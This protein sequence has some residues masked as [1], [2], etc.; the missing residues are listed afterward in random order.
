M[1]MVPLPALWEL[2]LFAMEL[3]LMPLF[4]TIVGG[5]LY[6]PYLQG[7]PRDQEKH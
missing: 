1:Q 4:L 5:L 3:L 2:M 7:P 6:L